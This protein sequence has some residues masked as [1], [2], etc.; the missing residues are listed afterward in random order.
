MGGTIVSM[1]SAADPAAS[2]GV[3]AAASGGRPPQSEERALSAPDRPEQA[4]RAEQRL[5]SL[6]ELIACVPGVVWESWGEGN[7][8]DARTAFV[9]AYVETMTGY[10]PEEWL[11]GSPNFWIEIMHPDDR[12]RVIEEQKA[13]YATRAGSFQYR[14][15]TKDGRTIWVETRIRV[16]QAADGAMGVRGVTMDI[17]ARRQ[18]EQAR[19]EAEHRE[20]MLRAQAAQLEQLSMPLIPITD[21]VLVMPLIG[22]FDGRRAARLTEALLGGLAEAR[23]RTVILDITGVPRMDEGMAEALARAAGAARLLGVQVMLTGV[24]PEAARALVA[25]GRDLEGITTHISLQ[26]GVAAAMRRAGDREGDGGR[27]GAR[28]PPV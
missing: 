25:L 27:R 20:E 16:V 19:I 11:G 21:E 18:A 14:W 15:V 3:G 23:A 24:R 1:R 9:S 22:E 4:P 12:A 2:N 13:V 6:E 10:S 8:A 26:R 28:R 17:T 7:P 5:E